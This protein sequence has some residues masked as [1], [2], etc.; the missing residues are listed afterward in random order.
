MNWNEVS[1]QPILNSSPESATPKPI[2][3][4][5]ERLESY[6]FAIGFVQPD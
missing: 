6:C 4:K 5:A 3:V 1:I 2:G